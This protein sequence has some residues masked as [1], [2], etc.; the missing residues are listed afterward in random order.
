VALRQAISDG[1]EDKYCDQKKCFGKTNGSN[2][3]FKTFEFRRVTNFTTAT[4]PLGVFINGVLQP[5]S[6]VNEDDVDSGNFLL[7]SI[8]APADGTV[9]EASYYYQWFTDSELDQF[10]QNASNWLQFGS[11]YANV[12][13]G[14]NMALLNFASKEAYLKAAMKYSVRQAATYK[15]EDAPSEDILKSI[16]AFQQMAKDF[17]ATAETMRNDYYTRSGAALAPN[18]GFATGNVRDPVPRR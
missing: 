12:P 16:Q 5:A 13:D 6:I 2:L 1:P 17:A 11:T 18:F 9:V 8:D 7:Q 10:L 15:L 14:L 4:W 3:Q